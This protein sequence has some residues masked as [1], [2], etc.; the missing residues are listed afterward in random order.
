MTEP[1]TMNVSVGYALVIVSGALVV[2]EF[3][4]LGVR[5]VFRKIMRDDYVM[6]GSCDKCR[7]GSKGSQDAFKKEVRTSLGLIK[8]ILL[9]VATKNE[10][11]MDKLDELITRS[12]G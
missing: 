4:R 8:G 10:I 9:I 12:Y 3:V 11:P 2:G 5:H 6:Q 1:A 7:E